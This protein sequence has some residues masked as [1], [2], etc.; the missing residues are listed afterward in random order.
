MDHPPH[1]PFHGGFH[2]LPPQPQQQQS[3]PGKRG[4]KKGSTRGGSSAGN[5]TSHQQTVSASASSSSLANSTSGDGGEGEYSFDL[6]R[7]N[8]LR[9]I[10][11]I[12]P[13][14]VQLSNDTKLAFSKAAVVFIMYLTA[15]YVLIRHDNLMVNV[16]IIL[17]GF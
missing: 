14:E 12:I 15:T 17:I 7:S 16:L 2:H 6:P 9:V 1:Q 8:V 5:R 13:D 3:T 4:P 11:R 10:R